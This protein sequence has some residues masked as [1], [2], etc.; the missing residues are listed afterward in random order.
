[1]KG[2]SMVPARVERFPFRLF[3]DF[4]TD[5]ERFWPEFRFQGEE[6][7]LPRM[8][9]F[10]KDGELVVQADLPGMKKNEVEVSVENGDL[11]LRGERKHEKEIRNEDY[12]R[13]ERSYGRFFRRL[14]LPADTRPDAVKA[15]FHDGVLDVH[16]PLPPAAHPASHK[17]QIH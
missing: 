9:V 11:V 1:M 15:N 3:D 17:I 12:F 7:F 13:A 14:P 2:K 8:D 6:G 16:V 4:G 5:L 10:E